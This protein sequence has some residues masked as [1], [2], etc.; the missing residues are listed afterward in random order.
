MKKILIVI[1]LLS[2]IVAKSEKQSLDSLFLLANSHYL[3][4]DYAQAIETYHAILD[5][6]QTSYELYYNLANSYFQFGKIPKSILYYEKALLIDVNNK[7]CLSNLNLAKKRIS[8]IKP[9]PQLFYI[10]WWN[11]I[12]SSLTYMTWS[13]IGVLSLWCSS[14]IFFIFLNN[15]KRWLFNTLLSLSSATIICLVFMFQSRQMEKQRFGIV[16]NDSKLFN[17]K[18]LICIVKAGNK[19]E[20]IDT[21][22]N[23]IY[24]YLPDGQSGWIEKTNLRAIEH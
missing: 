9:F 15:R 11:T 6:Q 5:S 1:C 3:N 10:R 17:D 19:I 21:I 2:A 24:V 13:V 7:N 14:L 22:K 8:I 18:N 12:T 4:E 20:L 16:M 23:N